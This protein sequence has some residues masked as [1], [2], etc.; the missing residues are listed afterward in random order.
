MVALEAV[1]GAGFFG[2]DCFTRINARFGHS[3]RIAGPKKHPEVRKAQITTADSVNCD[4]AIYYQCRR[5]NHRG[6]RS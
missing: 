5:D 4:R 1:G 2:G 3:F 6:W